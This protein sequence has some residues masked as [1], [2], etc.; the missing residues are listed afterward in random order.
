MTLKTTETS[1][2]ILNI[3]YRTNIIRGM[4][5]YGSTLRIRGGLVTR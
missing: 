1:I 5:V 2:Y 4:Y 3:R